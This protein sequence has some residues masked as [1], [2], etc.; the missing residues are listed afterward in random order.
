VF[1]TSIDTSLIILPCEAPFDTSII[2]LSLRLLTTATRRILADGRVDPSAMDKGALRLAAKHGHAA[3]I[4]QLL[5]H[6]RA[7]PIRTRP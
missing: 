2:I 7:D 4:E 3:V 6:G 5:A 1:L